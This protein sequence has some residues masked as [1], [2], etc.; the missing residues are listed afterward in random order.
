MM[1][2]QQALRLYKKVPDGSYPYRSWYAKKFPVGTAAKA[3]WND[4]MFTYG[5]EYGML[6]ALAKAFDIMPE[7]LGFDKEDIKEATEW[8]K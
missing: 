7:E 5:I 4:E 2:R 8:A 6:I 1:T 3:Y